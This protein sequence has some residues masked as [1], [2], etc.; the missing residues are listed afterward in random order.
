MRLNG[1]KS[2]YK[3]LYSHL[4]WLCSGYAAVSS[5]CLQILVPCFINIWFVPE[6]PPQCGSQR[7]MV[8]LNLSQETLNDS[9]TPVSQWYSSYENVCCLKPENCRLRHGSL[10]RVKIIFWLAIARKKYCIILHYLRWT[11]TKHW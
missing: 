6:T 4:F 10:W 7:V 5:T 1:K 3:M 9:Y 11:T 8:H 2:Q